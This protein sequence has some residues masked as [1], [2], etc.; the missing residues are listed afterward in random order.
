MKKTFLL[1]YSTENVC[2]LKTFYISQKFSKIIATNGNN[3]YL[4]FQI[5]I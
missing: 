1:Y 3:G 5:H 2:V 4:Y